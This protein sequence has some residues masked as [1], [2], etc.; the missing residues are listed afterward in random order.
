MS[1]YD[2]D[3]MLSGEE[4]VGATEI[5]GDD[6][7]ELLGEDGLDEYIV[8]GD[9]D[10][11]VGAGPL[12][13][14]NP[15]ILAA[16]KMRMRRDKQALALHRAELARI[17]NP[18]AIAVKRT[19]YR[20]GRKL[21][22][23]LAGVIPIGGTLTINARS[24]YLF[25]PVRLVIP[26]TIAPSCSV[27]SILMGRN[28]QLLS[29]TPVPGELFSEVA[30]GVGVRFDSQEIGQDISVTVVN[31]TALDLTFRAAFIGDMA[32]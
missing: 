12:R 9:D 6:I 14:L 19:P 25:R 23:G 17:K 18:N 24:Q 13:G 15:R 21:P 4:I 1:K 3:D 32:E 26:S 10:E 2:D 16:L 27:S 7:A 11:I 28:N 31:H 8:S 20:E 29:A 30:V 5:V 22:L